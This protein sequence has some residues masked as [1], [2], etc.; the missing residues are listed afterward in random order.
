MNQKDFLKNIPHESWQKEGMNIH[1]CKHTANYWLNKRANGV[2][3][4]IQVSANDLC[5]QVLLSN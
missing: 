2:V 1:P 4:K 3:V 5:I